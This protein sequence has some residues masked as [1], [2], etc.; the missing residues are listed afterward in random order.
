M[1]VR[2]W[3]RGIVTVTAAAVIILPFLFRTEAH[4]AVVDAPG[5]PGA[6]V[7]WHDGDTDGVGTST[8]RT[9]KVWYTLTNGTLSE[10]YHPAADTPNVR[11]LGFMVPS[12]TRA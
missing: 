10:T 11:D 8:T 4:A 9:S 12:P 3:T 2:A 6:S 5:A 7:T 1:K